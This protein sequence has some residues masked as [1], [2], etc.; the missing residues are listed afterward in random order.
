MLLAFFCS[1][2]LLIHDHLVNKVMNSSDTEKQILARPKAK[3]NWIFEQYW[4]IHPETGQC[5]KCDASIEHDFILTCFFNP[6]VTFIKTNLTSVVIDSR[7]HRYTA[8]IL[9][10]YE[11]G[12]LEYIECKSARE[13]RSK[14]KQEKFAQLGKGYQEANSSLRVV[15]DEEIRKGYTITNLK[16]FYLYLTSPKPSKSIIKVICDTVNARINISF[17][18]LSKC[19]KQQGIYQRDIWCCLARRYLQTDIEKYIGPKSVIWCE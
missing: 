7:N 18:E 6:E 9:I 12:S 4:L 13:M 8:D 17:A 11:N 1:I 16:R 10:G 19:L 5:F 15:T 14:K 2:N 3:T